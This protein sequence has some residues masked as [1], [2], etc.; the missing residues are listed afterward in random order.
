MTALGRRALLT[1]AGALVVTAG[2]AQSGPG[3][4]GS[5]QTGPSQGLPAPPAPSLPG[6]QEETPRQAARG[7]ARR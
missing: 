6:S 5:G 2:Y 3:Q 7:S 1:A 4:T